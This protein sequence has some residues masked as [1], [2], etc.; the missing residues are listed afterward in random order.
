MLLLM[1]YYSLADMVIRQPSILAAADLILQPDISQTILILH[2]SA[3]LGGKHF[4][5]LKIFSIAFDNIC[6]VP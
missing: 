3:R 2:S 6:A 4:V 1:Y 5:K